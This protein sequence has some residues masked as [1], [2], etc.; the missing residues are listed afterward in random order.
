MQTLDDSIY[1]LVKR[2]HGVREVVRATRLL[3]EA[4]LKVHY[5]WMPGLPGSSLTHDLELSE[6]LFADPDFVRTACRYTLPW[7][8]GA[9]NLSVGTKKACIGRTKWKT[10]P[11][12][13]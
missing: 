5:H 6:K 7:S 10:W 4:G 3:K 9:L 13:S 2:G 11:G 1:D 8:S 12:S